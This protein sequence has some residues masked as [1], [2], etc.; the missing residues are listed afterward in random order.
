MFYFNNYDD[1]SAIYLCY[2]RLLCPYFSHVTTKTRTKSTM[3]YVLIDV[4]D[5][6]DD[7]NINN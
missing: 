3:G 1:N 4:V 2:V 6:V 7:T 5:V